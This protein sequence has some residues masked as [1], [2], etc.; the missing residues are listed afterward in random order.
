LPLFLQRGFHPPPLLNPSPGRS[1]RLT[2]SSSFEPFFVTFLSRPFRP[3]HQFFLLF[4]RKTQRNGP[5]EARWVS[6]PLSTLLRPFFLGPFLGHAYDGF[7]PQTP[8]SGFFWPSQ[9][10][11]GVCISSVFL[12]SFLPDTPPPPLPA[13]ELSSV[14]FILFEPRATIFPCRT[15]FPL[16]Y[17]S[18][19]ITPRGPRPFFLLLQI[20]AL[21]LLIS[22]RPASLFHL[23]LPPFFFASLLFVF[24]L[25][26]EISFVYMTDSYVP[27]PQPMS[28]NQSSSPPH[29]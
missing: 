10:P 9:P 17:Y 28:N 11:C 24:P 23:I 7:L 18:G 16:Y 12:F 4:L 21:F 22:P 3:P 13:K 27:P 1:G 14:L 20:E 19:P 5:E 26:T 29:L 15:P 2:A 8:F 6:P 25:L